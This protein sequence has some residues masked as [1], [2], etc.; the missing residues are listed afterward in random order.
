M[1]CVERVTVFLGRVAVFK[2][3]LPTNH[4]DRCQKDMAAER[5]IR[6]APKG[7]EPNTE[8]TL[9]SK[10]IEEEQRVGYGSQDNQAS[11]FDTL[12]KDRRRYTGHKDKEYEGQRDRIVGKRIVEKGI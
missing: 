3:N 9:E 5:L 12:R 8:E 6:D 7:S 2:T 4:Q 1:M 11:T 10:G